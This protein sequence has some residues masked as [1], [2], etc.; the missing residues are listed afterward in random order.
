MN[1]TLPLISTESSHQTDENEDRDDDDG[2]DDNSD[3]QS[4]PDDTPPS[5]RS[6]STIY[7][8]KRATLEQKVEKY[9]DE[10][11]K[12]KALPQEPNSDD[13]DFF[14][15]LLPMLSS[16]T[17][18]EKIRFR[19]DVLRTLDGYNQ[20]T[21]NF[22]PCAPATAAHYQKPP[23]YQCAPPS[24]NYPYSY[25]HQN[26]YQ[27]K[28]NTPTHSRQAVNMAHRAVPATK[29]YTE[30]T[31]AKVAHTNNSHQAG[32]TQNCQPLNSNLQ[33]YPQMT[34]A[35][36]TKTRL[37]EQVTSKEIP[38]SCNSSVLSNYDDT[39]YSEQD[40]V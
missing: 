28:P 3:D 16:L 26:S 34:D 37:Q 8:R 1:R 25:Q 10:A 40:F 27:E 7:R 17:V 19:M 2:L 14:R 31:T 12:S 38:S 18:Q 9:I 33:E 4:Q 6:S 32:I 21:P 23:V 22:P 15:S 36:K 35:S 5:S 13:M 24:Y 39:Y 30:L 11:S 29:Q 20:R